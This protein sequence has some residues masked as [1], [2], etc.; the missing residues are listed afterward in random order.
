MENLII[1]ETKYTP[2][3]DLDAKSGKIEIKGYSYPESAF[4]FYEPVLEW[5]E[6]Y[7]KE[8]A[9]KKTKVDFDIKNFNPD[10]SK[11]F[12]EMLDILDENISKSDI[13]VSWG[14]EK[15]NHSAEQMAKE[16]KEDFEDLNIVLNV[17]N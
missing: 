11:L 9:Q 6:I 10:S 13:S 17:N 12:F 16:L 4:E 1:G 2:Q 14:Y 15:D 5:I 8:S 3:I 7:F